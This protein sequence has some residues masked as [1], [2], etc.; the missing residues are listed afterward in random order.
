M[1]T[2]EFGS[3]QAANRFRNQPAVRQHLTNADHRRTTTVRLSASAPSRVL[4]RAE[5]QAFTT[6]RE[7]RG[8]A[9]MAELSDAEIQSLERQHRTFSWQQHGFEAMRT[10]AA[11]QR[12]GVT[13]WQDHFE[14]GEGTEGALE[15]LRQTKQMSA[16][17]GAPASVERGRRTDEEELTGDARQ[18]RQAEAFAGQQL[19]AAKD[20]ALMDR[21]REAQQ[22]LREEEGFGDVFDIRFG[23]TDRFGRPDPTGR[24]MA[25]LEEFHESRSQRSQAQDERLQAPVTRDPIEWVN[26]PS[27]TDFPGVD[28]LDP[29]LV[30]ESRSAR[31]RSVDESRSAPL[32]SSVEAWAEEPDQL[33]L[34][35]VDTPALSLEDDP[36]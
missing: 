24:A 34:P 22:F 12:S 21:E 5:S 23:R 25:R 14:P 6:Q 31:S 26:N 2:V 32:A 33:D 36:T 29:E 18:R 20:A 28:T 11:L 10:K 30:H 9:G 15:N 16:R 3:R 19:D 27:T 4:E 35:G 1:P 13:D 17:T 7:Q 8:S